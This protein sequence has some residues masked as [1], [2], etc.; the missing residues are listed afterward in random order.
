MIILKKPKPYF[1]ILIINLRGIKKSKAYYEGCEERDLS[2][3]Y[4]NISFKDCY[5]YIEDY[6]W[7]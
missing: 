1:I 6:N 7:K 5:D 4:W 2:N 3:F